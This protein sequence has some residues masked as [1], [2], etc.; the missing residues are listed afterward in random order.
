MQTLYDQYIQERAENRKKYLEIDGYH[1]LSDIAELDS[2]YYNHYTDSC[3]IRSIITGKLTNWNSDFTEIMNKHIN[4]PNVNWEALYEYVDEQL[5][6]VPD[7]QHLKSDLNNVNEQLNSY[8]EQV[9][10]IYTGF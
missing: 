7:N 1:K 3:V 2:Y 8:R 10:P 9:L 5:K 6:N 4:K